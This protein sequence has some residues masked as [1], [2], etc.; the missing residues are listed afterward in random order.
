MKR[1]SIPAPEPVNAPAPIL[2][3]TLVP[4]EATEHLLRKADVLA[5]VNM[6]SSTL[7]KYIRAGHF[8]RPQ[9]FGGSRMSRWKLS[10]VQAYING[11]Y[12]PPPVEPT[13]SRLKWIPKGGK[14]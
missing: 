9:H 4:L 14:V 6:A 8:P 1:P 13:R 7:Y 11:T 5:L 10:E 2:L 12:T 3:N